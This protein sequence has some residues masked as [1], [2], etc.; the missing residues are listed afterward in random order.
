MY[1]VLT[2][3]IRYKDISLRFQSPSGEEP[4][5]KSSPVGE[6]CAAVHTDSRRN[7]ICEYTLLG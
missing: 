1:L 7:Q 2:V 5:I 4:V 3:T 6:N